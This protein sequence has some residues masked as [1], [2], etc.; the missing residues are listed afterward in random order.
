[1]AIISWRKPPG[2]RIIRK[3]WS[4]TREL[5]QSKEKE[6][7]EDSSYSE[8]IEVRLRETARKGFPDPEN[9]DNPVLAPQDYNVR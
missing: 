9:V 3:F 2:P 8:G 1:M 4:H 6:Q 5:T 7:A